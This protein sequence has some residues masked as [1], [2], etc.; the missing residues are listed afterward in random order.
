MTRRSAVVL[1]L[2]I[3]LAEAALAQQ[4]PRQ[5]QEDDYTRYELL[6]PDTVQFRILS[7]EHQHQS[8]LGVQP[9]L[10]LIEDDRHG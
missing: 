8:L 10:C 4:A 5:T 9:V 6:A 3:V 2:S 7:H 1:T